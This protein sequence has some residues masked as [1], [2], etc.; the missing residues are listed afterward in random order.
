MPAEKKCWQWSRAYA[1]MGWFYK[2]NVWHVRSN[3][4]MAWD[5][6]GKRCKYVYSLVRDVS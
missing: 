3:G 6:M 2:A 1:L 4:T 5:G